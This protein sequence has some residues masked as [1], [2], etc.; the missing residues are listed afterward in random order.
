[1]SSVEPFWR[2]PTRGAAAEEGANQPILMRPAIPQTSR[3][4]GKKRGDA[5]HDDWGPH[6]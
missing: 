2:N 3:K 5:M 1:M 6:A 4:L